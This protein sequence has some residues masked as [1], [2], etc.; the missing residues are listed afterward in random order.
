MNIGDTV[1]W[2]WGNGTAEGTIEKEYTDD[3]T[4]E[5]NG[6]EISRNATENEP[7]FLIKQSDGQPVLKSI[8]EIESKNK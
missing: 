6:T 2:E 3:V 7:A 8:T 5:I 1:Y 4:L